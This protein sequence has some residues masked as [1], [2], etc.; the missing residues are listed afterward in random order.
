VSLDSFATNL[1]EIKDVDDQV[2][3][4]SL[5]APVEMHSVYHIVHPSPTTWNT[6]ING[7]KECLLDYGHEV[8][9]IPFDGWIQSLRDLSRYPEAIRR[10]PALK[11]LN[12]FETSLSKMSSSKDAREAMGFPLLDSKVTSS[13]SSCLKEARPLSS[14][15]IQRWLGY[16]E[17]HSLLM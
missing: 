13:K 12:F 10:T 3:E 6:V 16:W 15:D 14:D 5:K 1:R 9:T 8:E 2:C 17:R 7:L 4:L 11:L